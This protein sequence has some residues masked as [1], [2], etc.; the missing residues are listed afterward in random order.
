M[1]SIFFTFNFM[2]H[3]KFIFC[4]VLL[5]LV[6]SS[7][8]YI[9]NQLSELTR[10]CA[11][12]LKRLS[13]IALFLA[14]P[15]S[16]GTTENSEYFLYASFFYA[17]YVCSSFYVCRMFFGYE[18]FFHFEFLITL[19]IYKFNFS[20]GRLRTHLS[21]AV[22]LP[23]TMQTPHGPYPRTSKKVFKSSDNPGVSKLFIYLPFAYLTNL[24]LRLLF[25]EVTDI[26]LTK[27]ECH[28]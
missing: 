25:R 2:S 5:L 18:Q 19:I 27:R 1:K 20:S 9:A 16:Y 7:F 3:K 23:G 24:C 28:S 6:V 11:K 15:G 8:H 21:H 22:H 17:Q 4:I 12:F 10:L 14:I 13:L 26:F